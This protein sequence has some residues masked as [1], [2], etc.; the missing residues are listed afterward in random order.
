M[1]S[2][3]HYLYIYTIYKLIQ[4]IYNVKCEGKIKTFLQAQANSVKLVKI[5]Q[6]SA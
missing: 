5:S 6:Q 4:K 2:L 3:N 1:F